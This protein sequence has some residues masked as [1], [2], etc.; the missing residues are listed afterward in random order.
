MKSKESEESEYSGSKEPKLT[1]IKK[2][3]DLMVS[4]DPEFTEKVIGRGNAEF[5]RHYKQKI[6]GRSSNSKIFELRDSITDIPIG[7]VVK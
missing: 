7:Q 4:D 2:K 1:N 3:P 5:L 6:I